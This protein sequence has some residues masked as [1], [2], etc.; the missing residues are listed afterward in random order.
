MKDFLT[1]FGMTIYIIMACALI[2]SG[3][4]IFEGI[5]PPLKVQ[6]LVCYSVALVAID[7]IINGYLRVK[8]K[9]D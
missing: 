8:V 7:R 2:M 9:N 4:M 3:T 5:E 6:G 1:L